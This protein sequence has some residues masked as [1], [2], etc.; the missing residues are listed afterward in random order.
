VNVSDNPQITSRY[1][2]MGLPTLMLFKNGQ[3]VSSVIGFTKETRNELK[4]S[5]NSAL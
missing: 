5:L 1:G 4:K 2:V 3:P